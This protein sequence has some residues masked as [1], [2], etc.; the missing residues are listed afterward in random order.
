LGDSGKPA[1]SAACANS[2]AF[3]QLVPALDNEIDPFAQLL[4]VRQL[5]VLLC[6]PADRFVIPFKAV[7]LRD[8]S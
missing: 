6:A 4:S 3:F 1:L 7:E 2:V 5:G 8:M